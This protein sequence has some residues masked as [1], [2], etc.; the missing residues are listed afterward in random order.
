[1]QRLK[2]AR[3][4]LRMRQVI[5]YTAEAAHLMGLEFENEALDMLAQ[6]TAGQNSS[7]QTCKDSTA[8]QSSLSGVGVRPTTD[9]RSVSAALC[10]YDDAGNVSVYNI[11]SLLGNS[12]D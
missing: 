4:K 7:M 8:K 3:K 11:H 5:E 9:P 12:L 1:M 10:L 2:A 6:A